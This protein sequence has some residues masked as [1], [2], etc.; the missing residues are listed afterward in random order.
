M[1]SG[2]K[3]RHGKGLCSLESI[4]KIL[5]NTKYIARYQYTDKKL[6]ES[7]ECACPIIIDRNACGKLFINVERRPRCV[8]ARTIEPSDFISFAI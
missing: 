8:K 7:V 6:N 1:K 5:R 2:V 4:Q 3:T